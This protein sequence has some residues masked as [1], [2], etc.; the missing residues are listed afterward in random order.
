MD[1]N[2]V[3]PKRN[4]A[5]PRHCRTHG[6][7]ATLFA[8]SPTHPTNATTWV[9]IANAWNELADLRERVAHDIWL[10]QWPVPPS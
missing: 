8:N 6:L 10:P 3:R 9:Y 5:D 1:L 7:V 4:T 2:T